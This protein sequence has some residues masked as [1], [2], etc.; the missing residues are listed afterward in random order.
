MVLVKNDLQVLAKLF[1][2]HCFQL[3]RLIVR[4]DIIVKRKVT[5]ASECDVRIVW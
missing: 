2:V 1:Q 3:S 5:Q 4:A